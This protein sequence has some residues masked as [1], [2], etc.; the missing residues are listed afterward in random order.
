MFFKIQ[1]KILG[2]VCIL[3]SQMDVIFNC[4]QQKKRYLCISLNF[5]Q[6]MRSEGPT[7]RDW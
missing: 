7:S 5:E 1:Y 3:V 2:Y 4:Q 6:K